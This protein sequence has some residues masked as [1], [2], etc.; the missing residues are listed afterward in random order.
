MLSPQTRIRAIVFDLDGTLYTCPPVAREIVLAAEDLVAVSR[1][2]PR[3]K[4]REL[5]EL[6]RRRLTETFD[7]E[8][9]LTRICMELGIEVR[10]FHLA[11]Q[12]R[13]RPERHLSPDPVLGALLDSL[14]EHCELFIYTNN[15]LPLAKRILSLLGVEELFRRLYTIEFCWTPKPDPDALRR[16][17]EDIGRPPENLLFVGDRQQVDLILPA[18]LGISTL[19]VSETADLLQIHKALGI[20][21]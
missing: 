7:E 3:K 19:L 5:I 1:G 15:S 11:L 12:K 20:I 14:Q 13:V 10:E 8:P 16:V 18:S 4:G 17:L 6:A 21:P 2:I 9:T